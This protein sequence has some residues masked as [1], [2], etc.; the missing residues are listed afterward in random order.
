M[1]ELATAFFALLAG[2]IGGL[3][4]VGGG[5]VFVPA[6][7]ILLDQTQL[8]AT[9]TSLLAIVPVAMVGTW[10]QHRHGNVRFGDAITLA[11]L[12]LPGVAVGVVVANAVPQRALELGFAGLILFVAFQLVRRAMRP[13]DA[14]PPTVPAGDPPR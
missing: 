8:V 5:I 2:A 9:A 1:A 10:R 4:G 13:P 6:L 11:L 3:L 12:S 7:V 14:T